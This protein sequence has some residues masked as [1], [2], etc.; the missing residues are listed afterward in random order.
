MREYQLQ[1]QARMMEGTGS[2]QAQH[3]RYRF[4]SPS[5]R[6][7]VPPANAT[8]QKVEMG[9]NSTLFPMASKLH[10]AINLDEHPD[11]RWGYPQAPKSEI[12]S[13]NSTVE[14]FV[15]LSLGKLIG[16]VET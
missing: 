12:L 3:T 11:M 14:F 9:S 16:V 10:S 7:P 13:L 8:G 2:P 6:E 15:S 1:A 5:A 4:C